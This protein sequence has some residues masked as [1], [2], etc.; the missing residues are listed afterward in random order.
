MRRA[1]IFSLAAF[2]VASSAVS[3]A[4]MPAG[5]FLRSRVTNVE[6]LAQ[7][8]VNDAIVAARYA[9]HYRTPRNEVVTYFEN[10]LRVGRLRNDFETTVFTV[11]GQVD[12]SSTKKVLPKGSY[13]FVLPNGTPILEAGTGNP[14]GDELP[15]LIAAKAETVAPSVQTAGDAAAAPGAIEA[16]TEEG[17]V[18]RVLGTPGMELGAVPDVTALTVPAVTA[19]EPVV[20]IVAAVPVATGPAFAS[21]IGSAFPIA[22]LIGGAAMLAGG[23]GSGQSSSAPVTEVPEPASIL[24]LAMCGSGIAVGRLRRRR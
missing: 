9:R 16:T 6:Q 7:Q 20:D 12:I 4:K 3:A 1:I 23:G 5:S 11:S 19:V 15:L 22:A 2:V 10:N 8:V 17:V 18:T 21:S 24:A 13:V 14:L